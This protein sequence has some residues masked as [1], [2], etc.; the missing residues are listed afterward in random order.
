MRTACSATFA[1]TVALAKALHDD[2]EQYTLQQPAPLASSVTSALTA[3]DAATAKQRR[4][5]VVRRL[6]RRF[7][8]GRP[9]NS[10][11]D[12]GVLIHQFDDSGFNA[13]TRVSKEG[14]VASWSP[15]LPCPPGKWCAKFGD[16]FSTSVLNARAPYA[17]NEVNGGF[18]IA[19]DTAQRGT[20]C[21]WATD[22]RSF[23]GA[24]SCLDKGVTFRFGQSN[25]TFARREGCV[26]GCVSG[27]MGQRE[28][29]D[30]A[31][32]G[33]VSPTWCDPG[34]PDSWC[35]WRPQ[36]LSHMLQQQ[37]RAP[38]NEE[39][40]QHNGCRYNE[41]VLDSAT[42]VAELPRTVVAVFEF[43][44]HANVS[45]KS[46]GTVSARASPV[47]GSSPLLDNMS[48]RTRVIHVARPSRLVCLSSSPCACGRR[49]AHTR[50]CS[51][52]LT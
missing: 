30:T 48:L 41:L 32:R 31:L 26:P 28:D 29:M 38:P 22:G 3:A 6:N 33:M 50:R 46:R 43:R 35:P 7:M 8:R 5:A 12:A 2:G 20:L 16:R 34:A 36:H 1:A 37:E 13:T 18:V 52:P 44:G 10:I 42:W 40:G 15:W 19:A 49:V 21:A 17:F 11:A 25:Q 45:A 39:C 4:Q 51:R 24:R 23:R 9:S 47:A 27:R 14:G